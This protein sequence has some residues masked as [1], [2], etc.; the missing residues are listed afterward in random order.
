MTVLE[1]QTR[2]HLPDLHLFEDD[3][4]TYAVDGASPNWVV[5]EP[6]GRRLLDAIAAAGGDMTFAGL[7]AGHAADRGIEAGRAWVQVHDFLRALARAGM[8]RDAPFTREAYPGRLALVAP[9]GLRELW[10][11]INN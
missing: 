1:A 6:D 10:L 4:L 3:G 5:L 8:L 11:Q 7:V 9:E 2:L